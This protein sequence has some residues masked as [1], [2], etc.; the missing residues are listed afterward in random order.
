[1]KGYLRPCTAIYGFGTTMRGYV[2]LFTSRYGYARLFTSMYGFAELC[3]AMYGY[4]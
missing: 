2:Q 4:V 3:K 1:M